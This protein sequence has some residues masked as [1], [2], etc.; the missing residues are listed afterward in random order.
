MPAWNPEWFQAFAKFGQR[1]FH[2]RRHLGIDCTGNDT[3][4]FH[5]AQAVRQHLLADPFQVLFQLIEAPRALKQ[6]PHDEQLPFAADHLDGGGY[7]AGRE[8]FFGQHKVPPVFS[9]SYL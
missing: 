9:V 2:P 4:G 1:I 6:I 3:I 8:F 7:R 5:R